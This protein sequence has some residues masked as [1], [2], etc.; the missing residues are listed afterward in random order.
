MSLLNPTHGELLDRLTIV[1]HKLSR[2]ALFGGGVAP[3]A[4]LATELQGLLDR[5]GADLGAGARLL[6]VEL[7]ALNA[8]IWERED[9][10]RALAGKCDPAFYAALTAG[11]RKLADCRQ[12]VILL[13]DGKT[14]KE[15]EKSW[16][17]AEGGT[18]QVHPAGVGRT[19]G[20][21]E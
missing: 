13:I 16:M 21:A 4:A 18:V 2:I 8:A 5:V 17:W 10:A 11:T 15:S 14:E 3:S 20:G 7:A 1:V 12:R 9:T 19:D 6:I